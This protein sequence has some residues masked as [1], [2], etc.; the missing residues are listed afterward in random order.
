MDQR[1]IPESIR[2][3]RR[4]VCYDAQK[5]PINPVTGGNA[6]SN[7]PGTWASYEQAAEAVTRLGCRG[8]GFML[9]DGFSGIDIDHCID[10]NTGEISQLAQDVMAEMDSYTEKS[11]SGTG[12]HI[13]WRGEKPDGACKV[14]ALGLEMY[15]RYRYF[16][17]TGEQVGEQ[18][19]LQHRTEEAAR[20]HKK[21]MAREK[22]Q[23]TIPPTRPAVQLDDQEILQKAKTSKDGERFQALM[24]GHWEGYYA[25]QSEAD[26]G[27][28]NLLAFWFGCDKSRMDA[29]FRASGL[30]R[31]KWDEKRGGKTYGQITVDRAVE[32]CQDVYEPRPAMGT[33]EDAQTFFAKREMPVQSAP[34]PGKKVYSLDDTGN[35]RRFADLYGDRVRYNPIDRCWL[36]WNGRIWAKD[37]TMQVKLLCDKMLDD[38]E[39]SLFGTHDMGNAE[40][41]RKHIAKSRSSRAKEALI[42]ESQHL[43]GVPVLPGQLDRNRGLLNVENGIVDLSRQRLIEHDRG[44]YITRMAGVSYDESAD[45]PVWRAFIRSVTGGDDSLAQ[46]LQVMVGYMLSGSVREQ[47]L[48]FL[49]GDG[50]NGKSTFL[51]AISEM[52]GTYAMNTQSET[53]T[54]QK[55]SGGA[56]S[57]IARL[58]GARLV[59]VSESEEGASLDESLV[60]QLTGGDTITARFLYGKEFEFRPEFKIIMATNH[61]PKIKGTD[62]GI[63]RRIRLVPFTQNIPEDKQDLQLPEKLRAE[64]PG[65]LNWALEGLRMWL[66][67]SENGKRRGL[68]RCQAVLDATKEYRTEQDRLTMF[69]EDCVYDAAGRSLQAGIFYRIY[70]KWCDENGER[71]PMN[72]TKFGRE[73]SKLY[74]K[75]QTMRFAEYKDIALTEDGRKYLAWVT[76]IPEIPKKQRDC[77]QMRM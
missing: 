28:C 73:V 62:T 41:M 2:Q 65:I 60:K 29:V 42:K 63:W 76:G 1:R 36:I 67:N 26:L 6:M 8:L 19:E 24:A 58:K 56:R 13:L 38:M 43:P 14:S 30:F 53:I 12:I 35:A 20:V 4:W 49:F 27:L 31:P 16:T 18:C 22:A 75:R 32:D 70:Q 10:P 37:D 47:C 33:F 64:K 9:G 50:S 54:S 51:D 74:E 23:V 57:D 7:N 71:Y 59:T 46:Y 55:H 61:K 11:P 68:P 72:S 39:R 17:V 25:S 15:S 21:Y 3:A 40:A 45:C 5:N 52:F 44:R 48:F 69:L 77:E 34:A 66:I